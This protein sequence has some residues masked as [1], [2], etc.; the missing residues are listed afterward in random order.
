[1]ISR[2]FWK[3]KTN[4][5]ARHSKGLLR[6]ISEAITILEHRFFYT[7]TTLN[8]V[9]LLPDLSYVIV[10]V[11]YNIMNADFSREI[12]KPNIGQKTDYN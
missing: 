12:E 3:I 4:Q 2:Q 8:R 9:V 1:M 7:E 5:R 11:Y 10:V 6:S